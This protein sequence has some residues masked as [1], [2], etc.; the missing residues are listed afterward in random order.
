MR[1]RIA[2]V[3]LLIVAGLLALSWKALFAKPPVRE[4]TPGEILVRYGYREIRPAS[5]LNGPGTINAIDHVT[6]TYL[7]LHRACKMEMKEIEDTW[8]A[9]PTIGESLG[10]ELNGQ[11]NLPSVTLATMKAKA[12]FNKIKNVTISF[13]NTRV[14]QL[15]DESLLN[16]RKKYF[17]G[18]CAEVIRGYYKRNIC[19]TQP[20]EVL[21]SD[22]EYIIDYKVPFLQKTRQKLLARFKRIY[23]WMLRKEMMIRYRDRI[24][25]LESRCLKYVSYQTRQ[26]PEHLQCRMLRRTRSD[27]VVSC[28]R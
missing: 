26:M 19:V 2:F 8:A 15:D 20:F 11:F 21:R 13:S 16:I 3:G 10:E 17:T 6:S 12:G 9:S 14:I 27:V 4:A 24:Y 28:T 7:M 22:I 23:L 25:L 18:D 1:R 5:T